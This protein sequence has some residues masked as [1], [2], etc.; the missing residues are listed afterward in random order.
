MEEKYHI[1]YTSDKSYFPHLLTSIYS[2]LE[3]NPS[4]SFLIHIIYTGFGKEEDK[5]L[6]EVIDLYPSSNIQVYDM[7]QIVNV[8]KKFDIPKWKGVDIAN[9]RLFF[10]DVVPTVSKLLYLDCDTTIVNCL[11]ELFQLDISTPVAAV[12]EIVVPSHMKQKVNTYY[13][14]GVLLFNYKRWEQLACPDLLYQTLQNLDRELL[15]PDQDLLNLSLDN[16][17]TPLDLSYNLV[18]IIATSMN[19]PFIAKKFYQNRSYFYEYQEVEEAFRKPHILHNLSYLQA[20]VW[21]Q[22][23]VHP[24][25]SSYDWYRAKWDISYQKEK[26]SKLLANLPFASALIL[27][28]KTYAGEDIH[29]KVKKIVK[30][31]G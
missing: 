22:N 5:K 16:E 30:K 26:N 23:K 20:R 17:I 13:N 10:H 9:A 24:F 19:H 29:Q 12:K 21:Q 27:A 6:E 1:L 15:Y 2:L 28:L 31:I 11:D 3:N 4:S 18:P 7:N 25:T 8:M 14:G